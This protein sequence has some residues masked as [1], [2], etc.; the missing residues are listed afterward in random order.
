M[1]EYI[2]KVSIEGMRCGMCESHINDQ[3]RKNFEVKK[4]KSNRFKKQTVI[5]SKQKLDEEKI[6]EVILQTG[7]RFIKIN[8]EEKEK[9]S[10]FK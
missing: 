7:Y 9:K 10:F 1:I 3:I 8:L 2:Y 6:K 5:V 4:V